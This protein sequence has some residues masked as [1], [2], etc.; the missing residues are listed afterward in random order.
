MIGVG[1]RS[2]PRGDPR[3]AP[4]GRMVRTP[5]IFAF[6]DRELDT[7]LYELRQDGRPYK[8]E[9]QVFDL[10]HFLLR[11]SDRMVSRDE[12]VEAIWGGRA[13]TEAT[14][15]TC[16]KSARQAIGDDGRAQ[17]LIR[18]VHG[19]GVRFVGDVRRCEPAE[20][21][22]ADPPPRPAPGPPIAAQTKPVLAVLP[23]DNLSAEVD[24]YFAD[25]LTEDIITNLSRFR[26]LLVIAR[27]STFRFKGRRIDLRELSAELGAGY[28]VQGS[29]RRAGGRVR[30]TARLIDAGTGLHLW[31]DHFDREMADLFAVQDDVT[32]T[33]A[34]TLGVRIQDA[35]LQRALRKSL[36]ELDAYDCILRARRYTASLTR[37]AHAEARDL[38][39]KAVALDPASADA[40]ALLANVYLAEHRFGTNPRPDPVARALTMAEAATRLDPQNAYARCWLAIVHFFRGE[41]EKFEAEARR[42]IAL[43]PNDPETLA[44]IG[45][46]LA[47]LGAF[48]R[49]VALSRRAQALNPLHPGWYHFSFARRHYDERAY[50]EVLADVERIAMPEFY[51][52]HLL[53]AA[54]LGQ[55]G[56][57]DAAAALRR[58]YV[59]KPDFAAATELRKWNAAPADAEHILDGLRKAGLRA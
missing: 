57:P 22:A 21:A 9:P 10:L 35:G 19:R 31:A 6:G 39:E 16:L 37:E 47:F 40:H 24:A 11:H 2:R 5:M 12:I 29:V 17:S 52:T 1:T 55:L 43:N 49:G 48:D 23:F 34:A 4:E 27:S 45:H 38:L 41:N 36:A 46:Y 42:A 50:E 33:I 7:E 44:D 30:V 18:T 25:G 56:R 28:V 15:S 51:W 8:V 20:R 53:H 14:I 58:L 3:A 54:A 32:R 13:V 26:D 59:L